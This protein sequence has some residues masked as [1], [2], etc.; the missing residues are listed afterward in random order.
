MRRPWIAMRGRCEAPEV[1]S[2]VGTL[3]TQLSGVRTLVLDR[4]RPP[5][6]GQY[7]GYRFVKVST[8]AVFLRR[9]AS[10]TGM[11]RPVLAS[12]PT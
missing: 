9:W 3:S 2:A 11:N 12:L 5:S 10:L 4:R 7:A 1:G 6:G 8:T